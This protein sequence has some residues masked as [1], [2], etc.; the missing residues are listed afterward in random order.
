[1][2]S[3]GG[4]RP[5]AGRPKQ[6]TVRDVALSLSRRSE[7]PSVGTARPGRLEEYVSAEY[8]PSKASARRSAIPAAAVRARGPEDTIQYKKR[9]QLQPREADERDWLA[10]G[11]CRS[12][13]SLEAQFADIL[14]ASAAN[15]MTTSRRKASL[16]M[17]IPDNDLGK[18][19]SAQTLAECGLD[20]ILH[21]SPSRSILGRE[22]GSSLG[23]FLLEDFYGGGQEPG[24]LR[25]IKRIP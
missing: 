5:G 1:M 12:L 8:R 10:K 2:K 9:S 25:G 21:G 20:S 23:D 6:S 16:Q 19:P 24:E 13:F 17:P 3:H 22:S 14:A 4:R 11:G 7:K 18:D 15:D